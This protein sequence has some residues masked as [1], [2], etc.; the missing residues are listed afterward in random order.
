[1]DPTVERLETPEECEQYAANVRT[2]FPHLARQAHRRAVELRAAA[3]GAESDVERE[4]LEVMYAYE[5][6]LLAKHGRRVRATYTWR[7]IR[8]DGIIEAIEHAVKQRHDPTGYT[9]LK[10]MGLQDL[11]FEA[12]VMRHPSAFSEQAVAQAAKRLQQWSI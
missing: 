1:M 6:A 9:T 10:E 7:K 2:E 5:E 4:G 12:L 8:S 3:H 11:T